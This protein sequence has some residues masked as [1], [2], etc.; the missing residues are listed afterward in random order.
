MTA[1]LRF[2]TVAALL[3]ALLAAG[4]IRAQSTDITAPAPSGA[5]QIADR[6]QSI[7]DTLQAK[8]GGILSLFGYTMVPDGSSNSLSISHGSASTG[9]SSSALSLSQFG[10]GFTVAESFPLYLEGYG[11]IAR[12]DPRA[13]FTNGESSRRLPT[14]WNNLST[15]IGIGYDIELLEHLYLRPIINAAAGYATSDAGLFGSF[16]QWRTG[17]DVGSVIKSH[18]NVFGYGGSMVLAYYDKRPARDIDVEL[19]YTQLHQE[20]FGDTIRGAR[21][22]GDAKT[23]G[24]WARYRWPTG[25]EAFGRPVRWVLD[26]TFTSYLGD[27]KEQLGFAWGAKVGGGLE[28]DVGR[29]EVGAMGLYLSRVR[30][31]GRYFFADKNITGASVGLGVSF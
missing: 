12:Y 1:R 7:R 17:I 18:V 11:G 14:R 31:I 20:T 25:M 28:L 21:G 4:P 23:L 13:Y 15:T 29:Y 19:R 2:G 30:L 22:A 24:L 26:G 9:G 27:Q 3:L 8:R 5:S 10:S 16:I 6:L